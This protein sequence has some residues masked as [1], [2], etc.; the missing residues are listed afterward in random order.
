MTGFVHTTSVQ[1]RYAETDQMRFVYH[2]NHLVYW[3]V[4]RTEVLAAL[5]F[6]YRQLEEEGCAI[7]VVQ[8]HCDYHAPAHYDDTLVVIV[9]ASM[10][11]RLRLRFAY[12]TRRGSAEGDLI[13][14]GWSVHVCMG[15]S[16]AARR[17]P[18]A[19][20]TRLRDPT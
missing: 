19:L 12:E 17:P 6:P 14:S 5:G 18:P 15:P 20:A 10:P 1:V 2:A 13:T 7:P 16:G 3:E 9:R 11:D 4:A 8:I